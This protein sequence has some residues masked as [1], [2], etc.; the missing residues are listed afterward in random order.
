M[1][2]T[3]GDLTDVVW[4]RELNL[5]TRPIIGR[6]GRILT[7]APDGM[8]SASGLEHY[9]ALAGKSVKQAQTAI[10]EM[11]RTSGDLRGEPKPITHP[12]KFY[13][14]GDRPL[15]I[16]TSRQWYIRNGGRDADLRA[17][18]L[19]RGDQLTWHPEFMQHRYSNWVD[20]LNGDWL[21]SRQ[22]YFGVPVP[23]W[24]RLNAA[25]EPDYSNPLI[26]EASRLPIDPSTDV[27]S[28]F[29]EAQRGIPGG[30]VGDADVLDTW[31]TSSLTPQI[32]GRWLDD[33]A[34]FNNVFPMDVRPQGHDII[35]TWLFATT[36]RSHFEHN[37]APWRNAAL[38]GWI[39]DPD[40]KK[41]SKSKGNVV[42]PIDL[43]EQY[44]SDAVR[45][46]AASARPGVDTAFSEDQMKVGRKLATKLLN[47]TKFVLG[48]GEVSA[49]VVPTEPLDIAMLQRLSVVI[50]DATTAFETFDYA[51]A[52]ERTESFFWWFCDDYLELVK[53][54]AYGTT[55]IS[56]SA[57]AAL[58]RAL[59]VM[60]RLFAPHIPFATEEVWSW[61][62]QNSIHLAQWPTV[63]EIT[64]DTKHIDAFEMMLDSACNVIGVIRRTKTE[65][66]LS[67][68][69][70]VEYTSVSATEAQIALLK[71][72]IGDLQNAGVVPA[73]EFVV[74]T[75]GDSAAH[76]AT[77]VRLAPVADAK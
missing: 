74:H 51:R 75:A 1:V 45:Y 24:Y 52:L 43:F 38:S 70:E 18:L 69:A 53:M 55:D 50:N 71:V 49:D 3:F 41:M 76:I 47:A 57:R 48:A 10:V 30:F 35:R 58:Q 16:V 27:P 60:Q 65:A 40:R 19:A 56:A 23:L 31:A 62:K 29:T 15:E 21:V 39:L 22:R 72:C 34:M 44:G 32:A 63:A 11:L 66:K 7:Q 54:R 5:P 36:V 59:S 33:P 61:W 67:Q 64:S 46:W 37:V 77:T 28:E 13:E 20:G 25:A 9:S 17:A 2:C 73:I 4:W 14:K 8:T 6:D 68:R 26:P 42:T 12:V